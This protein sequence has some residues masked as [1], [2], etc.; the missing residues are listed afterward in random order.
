[1]DIKIIIATHKKFWM[2]EDEIYLPLH[3]GK[4]GKPSLGYAGDDTGENISEKNPNYCELTGIY[5][6]YKNLKADYIGLVHYR[7]HFTT[8]P[9]II[10]LF[11][12][13]KNC[14]LSGAEASEI[15]KD[16]DIVVPKKRRYFIETNKSHY[17]HCHHPRDLAETGKI[18]KE[19]YPEYGPYFDKVMNRTYAHM[20]NMFIM[21]K[22]LFDEYCAFIFD[23]LGEL[24]SRIDISDYNTYEARVFGF[25]SE[26]LLDVFIEAKNLKYKELPAMFMEKQNW[27]IKI[28][29]F[30]KRKLTG[31]LYADTSK[32]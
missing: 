13:K 6:A 4:K 17:D 26:R 24:E 9:F 20:F 19:K 18:I 15:L 3:V 30:L 25:I 27:F 12:G 23:V 5:W 2:P 29:K 31:G 11:K 14:V 16:Y 32:N 10:R 8:K 1:M 21:R 7:R 28:G 22:P